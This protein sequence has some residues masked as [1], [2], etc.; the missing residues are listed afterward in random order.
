MRRIVVVIFVA[1]FVIG[2]AGCGEKKVNVKG[3]VTYNGAALA[4]PGG[5]II[6]VSPGG[7]QA[8]A[9]IEQDGT[10]RAV[11]VSAG[12]NQVAVYYPNSDFKG[13]KRLPGKKKGEDP[14][15]VL[16][17]AFLTPDKYASVETSGLTHQAVGE[18]VFDAPLVG[19]IIR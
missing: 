13:G 1:S 3:R 19:Q 9:S 11:G 8:V 12:A 5:Q 18:A 15:A 6:F 14:A 4:K 10:Y 16:V 2:V 7:N 17:P